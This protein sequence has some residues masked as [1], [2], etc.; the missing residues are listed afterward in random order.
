MVIEVIAISLTDAITAQKAGADRIELVAGI[1][2][3]GLT[4]SYAMIESVCSELTIPVNVMIRPH[5]RSFCYD[6]NDMKIMLKDIQICKQLGA[7]GIV[8]G[9]LT[10]EQNID[11]LILQQL[12]E[13]ADGLDITF[14]R[15]FDDVKDQSKALQTLMSYK[16]ISR[17]LTSGGKSKVLDAVSEI[18]A[19]E[20]QA[21]L[22]H[23]Q[24]MPGSGLSPK[25]LPSFLQHVN[26]SEF[27][28]GSGVRHQSSFDHFI[29][30]HKIKEVKDIILSR[31]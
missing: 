14:H 26:V 6:Q 11:E 15:A 10:E 12:I 17:I 9:A 2:E 29:D 27:H 25:T 31:A 18:Q 3:G 1:A 22:A 8:V 21:S 4:P 7:S 19:L 5:S 13:A 24:I 16:E 28:F 30:E 20:Q 23:M